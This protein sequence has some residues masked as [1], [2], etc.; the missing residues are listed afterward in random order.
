MLDIGLINGVILDLTPTGRIKNFLLNGGVDGEF[1]TNLL[2]KFRFR[3]LTL[4]A[5][6]G[7]N[8]SSTLR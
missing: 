3:C 5:F 7:R 4:G 2:G 6:I 1:E 8:S